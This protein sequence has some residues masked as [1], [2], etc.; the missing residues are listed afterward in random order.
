MIEFTT[1]KVTKETRRKLKIVSARR[2][3]TMLVALEQIVAQA[4]M[5][6]DKKEDKADDIRPRSSSDRQN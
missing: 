1:I 4:L 6:L 2:G 5:A 3:I